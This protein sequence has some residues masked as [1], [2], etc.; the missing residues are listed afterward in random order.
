MD[1]V[2]VLPGP[3]A[4][5]LEA[6]RV[7]GE[8]LRAQVRREPPTEADLAQSLASLRLLDLFLDDLGEALRQIFVAGLS[9]P[10]P[11]LPEALGELRGRA[12]ALHLAT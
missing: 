12:R 4:D 7:E 6:A 8:A 5:R 1:D 2:T 11:E 9:F 10:D 3:L